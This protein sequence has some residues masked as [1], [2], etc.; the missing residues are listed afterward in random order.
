ME[1]GS[2][3]HVS[4]CVPRLVSVPPSRPL[5]IIYYNARSLL[6][7][8]DE[9]CA[10]A[11]ANNPDVICIVESWQS[12]EILDDEIAI[13]NYRILRHGHGGGIV[14]YIHSSL[15]SQVLSVGANGHELLVVSV[16]TLNSL[17]KFCISLFYR[18]RSCVDAID[19]LCMTPF[20]LLILGFLASVFDSFILLGDINVDY[21]CIT[22]SLYKRLAECLSPLALCQV[23]ESATHH[24]PIGTPSLIDLVFISNI[25][26][27]GSCSV[28]PPLATSDHNGIHVMVKQPTP[29]VREAR[30][31][32]LVWRYKEANLDLAKTLI[33]TTN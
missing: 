24:S 2:S 6:P 28:I 25:S 17:C 33:E 14:M 15:S 13:N 7:K 3:H 12:D 10:V 22:T 18:P 21:F 31:P 4:V 29:P 8:L 19:T 26:Q 16:S 23:V 30:N 1:G 27:L 32:R 9:L 11:E 5:H 20:S